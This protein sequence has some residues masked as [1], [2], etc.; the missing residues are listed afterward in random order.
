VWCVAQVAQVQLGEVQVGA[1]GQVGSGVGSGVGGESAG[2]QRDRVDAEVVGGGGV[3]GLGHRGRQR[4][5]DARGQGGDRGVEGVDDGQG[6]SDHEGG[7]AGCLVAG[8][9]CELLGEAGAGGAFFAFAGEVGCGGGDLAGDEGL[10]AGPGDAAVGGLG[11]LA[12]DPRCFGGTQVP[13]GLGD[14]DGVG[15]TDLECL[16][17]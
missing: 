3:L 6:C 5:L 1:V 13:G 10:E 11:D 2:E 14:M 12:V 8:Q 7:H 15:V 16:D 17:P 4:S 9:G